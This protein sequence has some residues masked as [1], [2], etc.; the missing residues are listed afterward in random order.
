MWWVVHASSSSTLTQEDTDRDQLWATESQSWL[1]YTLK[2]LSPKQEQPFRGLWDPCVPSHASWATR[3]GGCPGQEVGSFWALHAYS[4]LTAA[5]RE[6]TASPT[7]RIPSQSG[8]YA[9]FSAHAR[10]FYT[11]WLIYSSQPQSWG[12]GLLSTLLYSWGNWSCAGHT[13]VKERQAET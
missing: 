2:A 1:G 10:Q 13:A 4:R 3:L 9:P 6:T 7:L 8:S 5:M 12:R 11:H